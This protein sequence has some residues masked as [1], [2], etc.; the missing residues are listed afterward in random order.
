[1]TNLITIGNFDGVHLG[2][3]ALLKA[4]A[5]KKKSILQ[6]SSTIEPALQCIALTFHPHP[7]EILRPETTITRLSSISDK[8]TLLK[9]YGIDKVVMIPFNKNLS[10]VSA[11]DFFEQYIR[12][13]HDPIF[14]CVGANFCFGNNR[15]GNV[16]KLKEWCDHA[17][18]D[19]LAMNP[20]SKNS[21]II[22]SSRIR[23][24]I[25]QGDLASA[26]ELLG[27]NHFVSGTIIH[28]DHRG[29][30]IGIPTANLDPLIDGQY[31]RALPPTGV[32]FTRS[33]IEN[34]S[35]YSLTNIGFKPTFGAQSSISIETHML[36]FHLGDVYE[37]RLSVEFLD[38]LRPEIN[39]SGIDELKQQIQKD[40]LKARLLI[41]QI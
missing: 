3:Q 40:I 16:E 28:G 14:L 15:E 38:R 35:F 22:S 26:T 21:E 10:K 17:N 19:F 36:D 9:Q 27:R 12:L 4:I 24:T 31:Q 25:T 37:K 32:Y 34:N 11:R 23:K 6:N 2:H 29:K 30:T 18:I 8:T 20:I 33:S 13:P 7:I 5:D 41:A 1:V 39:F